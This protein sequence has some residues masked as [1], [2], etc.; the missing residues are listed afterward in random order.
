MICLVG[1][2]VFDILDVP[3]LSSAGWVMVSP[4]REEKAVF[5]AY[6][7][8]GRGI[9]VRS[10]FLPYSGKLLTNHRLIIIL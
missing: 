7:P 1:C 6:T 8:D 5:I 2:T 3:P 4:R 10:P 9:A